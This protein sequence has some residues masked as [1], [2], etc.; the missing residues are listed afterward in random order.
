M[1]QQTISDP[2]LLTSPEILEYLGIDTS[3]ISLTK[4]I[5]LVL[6]LSHTGKTIASLLTSKDSH[7][8]KSDFNI[9]NYRKSLH[10][11]F[12][13]TDTQS[14]TLLESLNTMLSLSSPGSALHLFLS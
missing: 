2:A 6:L 13:M 10:E 14:D 8:P 4:Q 5:Q 11:S 7:D 9:D 12:Q 3:R 1:S